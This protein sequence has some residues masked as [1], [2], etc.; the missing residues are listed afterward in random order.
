MMGF[1]MGGALTVACAVHVP[2]LS[3]SVG[4]YGIPPARLADP[5]QIR[6]PFQ[7]HFASEDDWCTHAAV[8]HLES[9]MTQA[10]QHLKA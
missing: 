7:G 6:I 3:A 5:A 1:C 9:A 2:G 4:F 8:D 10:G